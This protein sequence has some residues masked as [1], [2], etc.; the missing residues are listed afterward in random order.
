MGVVTPPMSCKNPI[1][2][3]RVKGTIVN[4]RTIMG[5]MEIFVMTGMKG[6]GKWTKHAPLKV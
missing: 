2:Q 3:I 6:V 1:Q 4:A 5:S